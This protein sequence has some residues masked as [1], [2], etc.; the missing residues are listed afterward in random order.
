ML[1]W[2]GGCSSCNDPTSDYTFRWLASSRWLRD[3]RFRFRSLPK[4]PDALQ[5]RVLFNEY[6]LD[7]G[8][9]QIRISFD[10]CRGLIGFR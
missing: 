1:R 9:R 8:F 3:S 2:V 7:G 10:L 6:R 5:F 4:P